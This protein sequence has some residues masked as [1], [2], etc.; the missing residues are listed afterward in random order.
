MRIGGLF[1]GTG[2]LEMAVAQVFPGAAPA[3]F[4]EYDDAPSRILAAHWPDVPN[5]RDVTTV[6]WTTVE[7]VD[8]ITGGYP[9]QPFSAAGKRKGTD[10][11][12]HLW[13]YVRE[14]VRVLR[15]RYVVLENVAGHLSLGFGRVL[16]D[17]AEDGLDARWTSV[18]ASDVGA[19]HHRDRVFI[20]A[21]PADSA[22]VGLEAGRSP[23][24]GSEEVAWDHDGAGSL[25]A[26][27]GREQLPTVGAVDDEHGVYGPVVRRWEALTRPAPPPVEDRTLRPFAGVDWS[28]LGFEHMDEMGAPDLYVDKTVTSPAFAEWMQGLPAGHVTGVGIS[29][30]AQMKAIGNGI[31]V[32]QAAFALR[33]LLELAAVAS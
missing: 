15:P 23:V 29:R 19:P 9:C 31:C 3:W 1:A 13:P 22:G 33:S 5:L 6:D 12:R 7:P 28:A 32:P 26:P 11:E 4:C 21:V 27:G 30:A 20:L 10:D 16:G 25:A 8:I 24:G 14:A 17:M 2:G 18:R